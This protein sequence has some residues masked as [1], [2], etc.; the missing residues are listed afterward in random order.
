MRRLIFS[1]VL[2]LGTI[3]SS[4]AAECPTPAPFAAVENNIALPEVLTDLPKAR[5]QLINLWAIWCAPCRKELPMLASLKASLADAPEVGVQGVH[6]G[7]LTEHVTDTLAKLGAESFGTA[8]VEDLRAFQP[9][10]IHGLPTSLLAVN[11][12]V[13]YIGAGYLGEDTT[14]FREWLLC[15]EESSEK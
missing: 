11:G 10:S 3:S 7:A 12:K 6:V 15:L 14:P 5:I 1:L 8:S 2:L 4:Q 13:A 9:L